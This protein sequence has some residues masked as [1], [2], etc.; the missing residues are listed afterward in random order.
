[1]P[2]SSPP[3]WYPLETKIVRVRLLCAEMKDHKTVWAIFSRKWPE[4][5]RLLQKGICNRLQGK[6]RFRHVFPV[7]SLL[8][9]GFLS[10]IL[11]S[12][13]WSISF[14]PLPPFFFCLVIIKTNKV[15]LQAVLNVLLS[16]CLG[17]HFTPSASCSYSPHSSQYINFFTIRIL[18]VVS[19]YY[20]CYYCSSF[21]FL[22]IPCH[23]NWFESEFYV[24]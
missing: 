6:N 15:K 5:S 12:S 1:M 17:A 7:T 2:G 9:Q 3:W 16:T 21:I 22:A 20:C 13:I 14:S 23:L 24:V 18:R 10:Y 8:F 4:A 11:F 19:H